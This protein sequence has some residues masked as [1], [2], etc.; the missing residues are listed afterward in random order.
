MGENEYDNSRGGRTVIT[1]TNL[2]KPFI[3]KIGGK[4]GGER[5][6]ESIIKEAICPIINRF[7]EIFRKTSNLDEEALR[8]EV[9]TAK[10]NMAPGECA[11]ADRYVLRRLSTLAE[12]QKTRGNIFKLKFFELPEKQD[13]SL[14]SWF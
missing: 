10:E 3:E 6:V 11:E 8:Q 1:Q 4:S 14:N 7:I 5:S 13:N 9:E 2:R 12:V